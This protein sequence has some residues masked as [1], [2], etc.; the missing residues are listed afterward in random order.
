[1]FICASK[2]IRILMD[3][4]H[5][6]TLT[7]CG[8]RESA[9]VKADEECEK[10]GGL[11]QYNNI[12]NIFLVAPALTGITSNF[13]FPNPRFNRKAPASPLTK[14]AGGVRSGGAPGQREG[15]R[16]QQ[17]L[18][19]VFAIFTLLLGVRWHLGSSVSIP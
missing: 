12:K 17:P 10:R 15:E 6:V 4:C 14:R 3:G 2:L 19:R 18:K 9:D 8:G 7:D 13:T 11:A 5:S 1:M 16:G